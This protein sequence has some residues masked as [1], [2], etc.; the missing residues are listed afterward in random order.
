METEAKDRQPKAM[1][2]DLEI[3]WKLALKR[4]REVKSWPVERANRVEQMMAW[5]WIVREIARVYG[6]EVPEWAK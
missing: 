3:T 2:P 6:L 4:L 1:T 5:G